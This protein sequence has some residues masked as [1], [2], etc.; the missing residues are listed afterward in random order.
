MSAVGE[1]ARKVAAAGTVLHRYV[2]APGVYTRAGIAECGARRSA[3]AEF[4]TWTKY[5]TCPGCKAA[6]AKRRAKAKERLAAI[7]AGR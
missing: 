6:I 1:R 2:Q 5:V 7:E 4:T 3:G